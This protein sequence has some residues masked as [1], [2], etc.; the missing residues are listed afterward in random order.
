MRSQPPLEP[1]LVLERQG[2]RTRLA[3]P[4]NCLIYSELSEQDADKEIDDEVAFLRANSRTLEWKVHGHDQPHDLATRLSRRGF[5][6]EP[7][8]TLLVR[9]VG[10]DI[11]TMAFNPDV[12][13]SVAS[14]LAELEAFISVTA[15]AFGQQFSD[16][17]S[18]LMSRITAGTCSVHVAYL[19]REVVGGGR[20]EM[21][22]SRAFAGL[23]A[24][25]VTPNQRGKGIYQTLVRSRSLQ[26]AERGY[27]FLF[28]EAAETSRSI[29]QR[30][31]F[32][33]LTTVQGWQYDP[34]R[35]IA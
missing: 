22:P 27:Q 31:G 17:P 9:E 14:T 20:L 33:P 5:Q 25:G 12:T 11:H 34:C 16:D 23:F 24:A 32:H 35:K 13:I 10:E 1:G 7:T 29:L 6:P 3:G 21:P 15:T 18:D 4:Y 8:E 28:S 19:G 2:K 26:A 30:L